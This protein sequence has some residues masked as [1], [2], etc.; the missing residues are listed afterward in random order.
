LNSAEGL[1]IEP[2]T[3]ER[4]PDLEA[5][6]GRGGAGYGCWCMFFRRTSTEMASATAA[7]NRAALRSLAASD[8][9]PG[10]MAYDG[11]VPVGW[12]GLGPRSGFER[13]V[14]SRFLRLV[15]EL[16]T[17]SVVC[18][19]VSR[20]SRGR[21]LA[22][23]LLGGAVAYAR[24][25]GAPALEGYARE[26][27]ARRLSADSAYT[28]TVSLFRGAGFREV[29]RAEPPGGGPVRVTMRLEL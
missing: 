6:F 12:V 7:E 2:L 11:E 1:R 20:R 18:F 25:H 14:R 8:P 10:L 4:W 9:P 22:R 3:L 26:P 29:A 23:A 21:G 19:F 16:P 13:L 28:G 15:D 24:L 17:W 5:L 27:G